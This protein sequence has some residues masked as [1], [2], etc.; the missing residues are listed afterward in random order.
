MEESVLILAP[1]QPLFDL[2]QDYRLRLRWDPFL[3]DMRFLND[4]QEAAV[5]VR[6]WVKSWTGLT[7]VV[8]YVVVNRPEVVAMKMVQG[9]AF[10]HQFAG[11][12]RFRPHPSGSTEVIFRYVFETRWLWLRWL[13]DPIVGWVFGRDI[14]ERLWGLKHGVEQSGLLVVRDPP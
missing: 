5:G 8:E 1:Q 9:P 4:A 12:W 6:V 3:R 14:R 7:M 13:L 10:L 2:A 11:S